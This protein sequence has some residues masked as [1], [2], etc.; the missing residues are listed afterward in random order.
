MFFYGKMVTLG[1]DLDRWWWVEGYNFLN[2]NSK[3]NRNFVINMIRGMTRA[4]NKWQGYLLSNYRFDWSY[5]GSHLLK[6]RGCLHVAHLHKMVA[7]NEWRV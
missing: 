1:W 5:T 4:T 3:F 6:Q 7:D 2:Y